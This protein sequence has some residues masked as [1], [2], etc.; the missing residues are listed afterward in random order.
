VDAEQAEASMENGLLT[1]RIP[2]SEAARPKSIQ[3][4]AK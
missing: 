3:I 2:K 4:T 1:L